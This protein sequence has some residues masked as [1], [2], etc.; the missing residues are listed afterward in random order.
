[1]RFLRS[2]RGLLTAGVLLL[3]L[4]FL[5]R[6]GANGLKTRIVGSISAA[7]GRPV[8]VASVNLRMLPQPGFDLQDFV[9]HED[10]KFGAEPMLRAADVTA[11]LRL[12][13]LLRGRLEIARLDLT[14]PSLNL[15]RNGEGHWNLENL[16]QRAALIPV[17]PTGRSKAEQRPGFPY[18]EASRGRINL[19][20]GAEK[21]PYT[22]S[23]ADFSLWQDSENTWGMR[24]KAQPVRTDLN[25]TDTGTLRVNG[26]WQR[27][28]NLH[29]TP[30][31]FSLV[32]EAVQLGQ[33]TKLAFG[34][35]KGWRGTVEAS[36]SLSGT[37]ASLAVT[38]AAS[39][40]DFRRYDVVGGGQLRL[41]A[42][43]T[44]NYSSVD[45][46]VS[47]LAC[48]APVGG[49]V[50]TVSGSAANLFT[51]PTYDL[52][53]MLQAVPVQSGLAL[54]R[55]IRH[56]VPGDLAA[57][58]QL[59]SSMKF[60]RD[61]KSGTSVFRWD[62]SGQTANFRLISGSTNTDLVL[63]S[64]P[65]TFSSTA[66]AKRNDNLRRTIAQKSDQPLSPPHIDIGPFFLALGTPA[67]LTV[68]GRIGRDGYGFYLQGEAQVQ[69]LLQAARTLGIPELQ[70]SAEGSAK[71]DLEIAANWSDSGPARPTGKAQLR[72]ISAQVHGLN[73][74]LEIAS[75]NLT[76]GPDK[77]QAQNITAS[78]A[79]TSWHGFVTIPR[80]CVI[81]SGCVIHF[82]LHAD[83]IATDRLNR[84][85]NPS[86][87]QQPWYS[88][89]AA[90]S[91]TP[92]LMT[93]DAEGKLSAKQVLIRKFSGSRLSAEVELKNG[94]LKVSDL[95]ADVLGG[96]HTGEWKADFTSK[97]P[98]YSGGGTLERVSLGQLA[99]LMNDE[100][101]TGSATA[102]YRA[103]TSGLSANELF[104][105]ATGSLQV[106]AWSGTLPHI[107]LADGL[108]PLQI[109][110]LKAHLLLRD[111]RFEVQDGKLETPTEIF[112]LTGSA[113]RALSLRLA[114]GGVPS[115]NITGT[116]AEPH[117]SVA[118]AS[119]TRA[120]LKP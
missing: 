117:V 101:I 3:L 54:L 16:I 85:L 113:S 80:P 26:S 46:V 60:H 42:Q 89:L 61:S 51:S 20:F 93:V 50:I 74:P 64:V 9:V 65:F 22:L 57:S 5:V 72:S 28:A 108:A 95:H 107:V 44:G 59:D 31:R 11:S 43:C 119:E 23:T 97:P 37:P 38:A 79:G 66:D 8:E 55:H 100:W 106:E 14:E 7:L 90:S 96:K 19:K 120:A 18:I 45:N 76:L 77:V 115:F 87:L 41:A 103:T 2:R 68:R 75:A 56:G 99:G 58:G 36:V 92:F 15:V 91:P 82:D 35:D 98:Q 88:F 52:T 1:V 118:P 25:L 33:L 40:E 86:A 116:L 12:A 30:L 62:G 105:S 29:D 84:L 39:A 73:A 21:K 83:E 110:H 32:W 104:A 17:A 71:L 67:P 24:L 6:P 102:T 48:R 78:A 4:V 114:R 13:S 70:P 63:N 69:R 10:P 49:G 34:N 111:A 112:Q 53:S 27:A 109:R 47:N 94:K 81:S